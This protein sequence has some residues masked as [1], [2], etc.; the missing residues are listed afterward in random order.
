MNIYDLVGD[1]VMDVVCCRRAFHGR[2]SMDDI[3]EEDI[4]EVLRG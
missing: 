2:P 3:T 1:V 4:L